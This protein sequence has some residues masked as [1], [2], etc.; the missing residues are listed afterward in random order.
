MQ[1]DMPRPSRT[2]I[3]TPS[4]AAGALWLFV[5]R[6]FFHRRFLSGGSGSGTV[7]Q[8]ALPAAG[9]SSKE[10]RRDAGGSEC[11]VCSSCCVSSLA[12]STWQ[13]ITKETPPPTSIFD[14]RTL[15]STSTGSSTPSTPAWCDQVPRLSSTSSSAC[16]TGPLPSPANPA[17]PQQR[18]QPNMS[19]VAQA[20]PSANVKRSLTSSDDKLSRISEDSA[21]PAS[22]ISIVERPSLQIWRWKTFSSIVPV[23]KSR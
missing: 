18:L 14:T 7:M 5:S 22:V 11:A 12:C 13:P 8:L 2:L 17:P 4:L 1:G 21:S 3:Q 23:V 16:G 9:V 10:R 20:V 15:A 19:C 6:I